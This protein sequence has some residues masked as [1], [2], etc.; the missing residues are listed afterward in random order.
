FAKVSPRTGTPRANTLIVS[1]FCGVLAAA[2]PLARVRRARRPPYPGA[3]RSAGPG[4]PVADPPVPRP[5][6][7]RW[8]HHGPAARRARASADRRAR[9]SAKRPPR[10]R[11]RRGR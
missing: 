4:P 3:A 2:V 5:A 7:H 6:V 9:A 1:L 11:N 10:R 8:V